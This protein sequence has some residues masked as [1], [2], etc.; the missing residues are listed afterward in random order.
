MRYYSISKLSREL[1]RF[2]MII[3]II[4]IVILMI[5]FAQKLDMIASRA[6][7]LRFIYTT[8]ALRQGMSNVLI[9][10]IVERDA[11]LIA[12]LNTKSPYRLALTGTYKINEDDYS[13]E[14][15]EIEHGYLG[16]F[17][18]PP[19]NQLPGGKWYFNQTSGYLVYLVDNTD[20]FNTNLEGRP[21][22]RVSVSLQFVDRDGDNKYTKND[23]V[24]GINVRVLDN[25]V[26]HDQAVN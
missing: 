25:P 7:Q 19:I 5:V 15:D 1:S 23:S 17:V 3:V 14:A 16:E 8:S 4:M 13:V 24:S 10:Y 12:E 2:E 21:R 20:Y 6:E 26:W 9:K 11:K 18:E 22:I